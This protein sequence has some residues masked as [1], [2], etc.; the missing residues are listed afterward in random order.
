MN[1]ITASFSPELVLFPRV[2]SA[3]FFANLRL[4]FDARVDELVHRVLSVTKLT[5]VK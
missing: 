3:A 1:I 5:G 4:T 2:S